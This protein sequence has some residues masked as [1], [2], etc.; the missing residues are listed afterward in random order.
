MDDNAKVLM[1]PEIVFI[2]QNE[3]CLVNSTFLA[4]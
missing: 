2:E 4:G 3:D 1:F